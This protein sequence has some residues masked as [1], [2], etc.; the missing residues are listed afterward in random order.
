MEQSLGTIISRQRIKKDMSQRDLAK[1]I[2]LSNS[3]IARIERDDSI[4]PDNDT[5]RSFS[6]ALD[7]DYNYLLAVC[8]QIDDEPEIRMI[9]RAARN[10][11]AEEK[12][13]M[14]QL[15]RISFREAFKNSGNDVN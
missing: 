4:I 2:H 3:T 1:L 15:L 12:S 14:I 11:T 8:H 7:I 6:Q 13:D 9:Q 10:M 5:L